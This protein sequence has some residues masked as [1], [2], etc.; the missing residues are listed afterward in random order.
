MGGAGPAGKLLVALAW[1]GARRPAAGEGEGPSGVLP[2]ALC[3]HA[4]RQLRS[5]AEMP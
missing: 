5:G 3:S 1:P 2:H 4:G